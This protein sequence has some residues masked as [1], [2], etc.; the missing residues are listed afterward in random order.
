MI[1]LFE[2]VVLGLIIMTLAL[3]I[4]CTLLV[5]RLKNC[6]SPQFDWIANRTLFGVSI[7]KERP[8][9]TVTSWLNGDLQKGVNVF[10]S[11]HFAGRELFIRLYN[12]SLYSAF[13]KSYMAKEEIIDGKGGDLF[14]TWYLQVYGHDVEPIQQAEAEALVV[15]MQ[16]LAKRLKQLGSCFVFVITPSKAS[17]YPED[18][19]D[20]FLTK[21]SRTNR[22]QSNYDILVPLLKK[23]KI[24]Y[25]DGRQM[26]LEHKDSMPVRAFAK[27][28]THWTRAVAFF[29][30]AAL[31]QTIARESGRETPELMEATEW[32]DGRPDD[33]DDD[34]FRLLNLM[35]KPNQRY[36]HDVFKIADNWPRRKGVLTFVGGSF[37]GQIESDLEAAEIF[38]SINHYFYF[39]DIKYLYPGGV[40]YPVDENAIPWKAD[41]WDTVAVVLEANEAM[42]DSEHLPGF[43]MAAL[44]E[45][46]QKM[47][48]A[49][50]PGDQPYPLTWAFGAGKNGESLPKKGFELPEHALTWI[51]SRE[52][53]IDCPSPRQ[54]A[55][56]ELI[57][58]AV[59]F[60][61][62]GESTRIVRVEANGVP[63]GTLTMNGSSVHSY[64][65]ALPA[66][67]NQNST[68][69]LRFSCSPAVDPTSGGR[70]R[71]MGL[72]RLAL[73]PIKLPVVRETAGTAETVLNTQ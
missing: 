8:P 15:M 26:T 64:P 45:L 36:L 47:P 42:M 73:V 56:L 1:K 50:T 55:E 37:V 16:D 23:Y 44:A 19:P 59:P 32:I 57:V 20:R 18:I 7:K 13:D 28:G 14:Q 49:D 33:T 70:L 61:G 6:I 11:E 43:L 30:T 65:L 62:D 4:P 12:Q 38:E 21:L 29:P 53:E 68:M 72:A 9:L 66:V 24:P 27:T 35:E 60:L 51:S 58:E 63:V 17:V 22:W 2:K 52:A 71:A 67:A 54:N 25:V 34:L 5:H 69:R 39:R 3:P 40:G 41:F 46:E 31:L 10:I 48:T